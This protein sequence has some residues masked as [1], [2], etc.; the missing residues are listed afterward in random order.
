M[1]LSKDI[2][3]L[4]CG[5][6]SDTANP[7]RLHYSAIHAVNQTSCGNTSHLLLEMIATANPNAIIG[8]IGGAIFTVTVPDDDL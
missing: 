7:F 6:R 5:Y 1:N 4:A 8:V 3:G 2:S